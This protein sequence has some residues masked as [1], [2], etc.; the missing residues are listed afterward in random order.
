MEKKEREVNDLIDKLR[1]DIVRLI[2]NPQ[3]GS[4]PIKNS[5]EAINPEKQVALKGLTD[6]DNVS[7]LSMADVSNDGM[8]INLQTRKIRDVKSGFTFFQEGDVLVAKITPCMENGKGALIPKL[9]NNVGFGSTEFFVLRSD[10]KKILP[11]LLFYLTQTKDFREKAEKEMTG[12]SGHRR[13]PKSFIENYLIPNF[14]PSEQQQ[15]IVQIE[16]IEKQ[17]IS[18]AKERDEIPFKKEAIIKKYL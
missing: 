13:V 1:K 11:K 15:V 6:F 10:R 18:L 14:S 17:L 16:K 7:F 8:I 9:E 4:V 5:L 2:S 12:S 3:L